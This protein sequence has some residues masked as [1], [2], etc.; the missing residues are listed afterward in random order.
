[1]SVQGKMCIGEYEGNVSKFSVLISS[2]P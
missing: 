1:M 2:G